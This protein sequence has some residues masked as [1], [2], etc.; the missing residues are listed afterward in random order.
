MHPGLKNT[1]GPSDQFGYGKRPCA[2]VYYWA[3]LQ[4]EDTMCKPGGLAQMVERALSMGEVRG[5][6]PRFSSCT[7]C[8]QG[9]VVLGPSCFR[10][11]VIQNCLGWG[12]EG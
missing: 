8:C 10:L 11:G 3:Q 5:S 12:A 2:V 4:G 6:M 9:R 1:H 7:F